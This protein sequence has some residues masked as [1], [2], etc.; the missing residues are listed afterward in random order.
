MELKG[1]K[2][3]KKLTERRHPGYASQADHWSFLESTYFGGRAWFSKHIFK[4]FKE[5]EGEFKARI[6]RAYRFN[7]TREVVDL[8]NKYMFRVKPDRNQDAPEGLKKFWLK[9]TKSGLDINELMRS[10]ST[11]SSVFGR[12]WMV[13]DSSLQFEE[14]GVRTKAD[15]NLEPSNVYAYIISP[16]NVLD[17]SYDDRGEL[18][19]ILLREEFRDDADPF[20]DDG[21]VDFR[22]R[23]WT[24]THWHLITHTNKKRTTFKSESQLH[25]LGEVPVVPLDNQIT[26]DMYD[27]PALIADIAYLDRACANYA[28][29]LDAIIQD[30]TFSQLAL[31][32][33]SV[34]PG[35]GS[36]S[37]D[38][39]EGD[40]AEQ[41]RMLDVGTKRIFT[42]DSE[43]G[44]PMYL[45]PDPRQAQ[46]ILEAVQQIINEIY[47]SVGLAGERTKADN[48]KGI[49]NS[50]GIAKGKDFERVNALLSSKADSL[51]LAE[52]RIA[53][54]V[55]KW[56]GD[57]HPEADLVSYSDDFDV[58]ALNDEFYIA[59]QLSLIDTPHEVRKEH[60][61]K[62][63]DKLFPYIGKAE[64]EK[65]EQSI[66]N[67]EFTRDSGQSDS[68]SSVKSKVT[69]EAKRDREAAGEKQSSTKGIVESSKQSALT[70]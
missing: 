42:Y 65:L 43:A 7:H 14:G 29:N 41:K 62:I 11:K 3:L 19:W 70:E 36:T 27:S 17:M 13:I 49:D 38:D 47:H 66:E 67:W 6:E 12:P 15:D 61:I 21:F 56:T 51:E 22:Y 68:Q 60:M 58:R 52:N 1:N 32:A 40:D 18:N 23:L 59:M 28:S 26:D 33:Q 39:D 54:I 2:E 9:A 37:I 46:L 20:S 4:Y 55:C 25:D 48:S 8:V 64:K 69:E 31:P 53:R 34:I 24:K 57:K 10:A 63:L 50:S 30:Q 45:S 16:L 44:Q 35:G 5:G